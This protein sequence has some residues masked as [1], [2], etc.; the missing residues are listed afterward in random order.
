LDPLVS[1]IA[2]V[3][4]SGE[5]G[6]PGLVPAFKLG[7]RPKSRESLNLDSPKKRQDSSLGAALEN[8]NDGRTK[9]CQGLALENCAP[10]AISDP[11]K[12]LIEPIHC[13]VT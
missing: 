2:P 12:L 1:A 8:A 3:D 4:D 7:P 13:S 5:G 11:G 6:E 10:V 9:H